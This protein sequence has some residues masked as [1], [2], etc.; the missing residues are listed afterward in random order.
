MKLIKIISLII[1]L[2][3]LFL[4]LAINF[5]L[6]NIPIGS[7]GV[8]TKEYAL[9]G[10]KGVVEHDYKPGWHLDVGPIHTWTI[11]DS[12]VQTLEMTKD[13]NYGDVKER[14][15]VQVQ[16]S[17]GYAVSVDVTVKYF[18]KPQMAHKLYQV[19][20][21]GNKYKVLVRNQAQKTCMS[22]FGEMKTEDFY[23]PEQR[24]EKAMQ[25]KVLLEESL[26]DNYVEVVDVLIKDVQFDAE[27]EKKIQKKKLADQEVQ[28]NI[29]MA[30]AAQMRGKTQVIE[31][32]TQR[33]LNIIKQ[34]KDA[35]LVKMEAQ[36]NRE[37]AKI[38]ADY[39]LYAT[40]KKA[41]ADLV[42]ATK[43][44]EGKLLIKQAEAEGE[45][46]RN[47]AMQGVGG[48]TIVALEAAKN[49]NLSDLTVSTVNN[50]FLDLDKM[51]TKLGVPE[52]K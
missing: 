22:L 12:T 41:D 46:L 7:V 30:R 33:K 19:A 49:L 6:I 23:N 36:A 11:F 45:K 4:W 17:D 52:K 34:E 51:A 38:K 50:D 15:D 9:L 32:E 37:I 39:D 20:G 13:P 44:A 26:K 31:A 16:S 47:Q 2:G 10:K 28:L 42:S 29:S 24:R 18:I 5:T 35:E 43:G 48:S 21:A 1:I 25:A 3:V 8:L 40:Q 27:Y 14:D